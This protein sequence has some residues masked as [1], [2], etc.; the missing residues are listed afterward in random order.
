MIPSSFFKVPSHGQEERADDS[1]MSNI[2]A[3]R[4]ATVWRSELTG[5]SRYWTDPDLAKASR[6]DHSAACGMGS[7]ERYTKRVTSLALAMLLMCENQR[8]SGS[9]GTTLF[10]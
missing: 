10:L 8:Q 1:I 7:D 5:P 9:A 2:Q 4:V 6:A 3:R